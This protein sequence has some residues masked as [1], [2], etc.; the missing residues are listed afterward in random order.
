[1]CCS[2]TREEITKKE[3]T[4]K[5]SKEDLAALKTDA[6]EIKDE[7]TYLKNALTETPA[8]EDLSGDE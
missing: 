5:L 6:D 3:K 2:K 8:E 1:M 7:I 4:G